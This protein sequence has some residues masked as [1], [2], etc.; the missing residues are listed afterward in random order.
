MKQKSDLILVIVLQSFIIF[1]IHPKDTSQLL[2]TYFWIHRS[3]ITMAMNIPTFASVTNLQNPV[4][5][6]AFIA[7]ENAIASEEL[8]RD[9]NTLPG[10]A[11]FRSSPAKVWRNELVKAVATMNIANVSAVSRNDLVQT[12]DEKLDQELAQFYIRNFDILF[13][14]VAFTQKLLHYINVYHNYGLD[15]TPLVLTGLSP[16]ITNILRFID[17]HCRHA[18]NAAK[19]LHQHMVD[20]IVYEVTEYALGLVSG[21]FSTSLLE[22]GYMNGRQVWI[23]PTDLYRTFRGEVEQAK[24]D[25]Y[26]TPNQCNPEQLN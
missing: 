16:R 21:Q 2:T 8:K 4:R 19:N 24:L 23:L 26:S 18:T 9:I 10:D 25:S 17:Q 3:F 1:T 13:Q 6:I 15:V 7:T 12:I 22:N 14:D 11:N 20:M 5:N